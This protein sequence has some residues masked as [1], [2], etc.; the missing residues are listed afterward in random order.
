MAII[1]CPECEKDISDKAAFCP[2][3][4]YPIRKTDKEQNYSQP[5]TQQKSVEQYQTKIEKVRCMGY[6]SKSLQEKLEKF[7]LEGWEIVSVSSDPMDSSALI[8]TYIVTM[9][10]RLSLPKATSN[11]MNKDA[12]ETWLCAC[13]NRNS[14]RLQCCDACFAN[15]PKVIGSIFN[16]KTQLVKNGSTSTGWVCSCGCHNTENTSSCFACF[17]ARPKK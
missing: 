15:R 9:R 4:G 10:R 3:C 7:R 1:S 17:A 6:G 12:D 14:G 8:A 11:M 5:K 13:G 2:H 16:K